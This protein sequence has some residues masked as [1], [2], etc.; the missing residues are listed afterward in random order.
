MGKIELVFKFSGFLIQFVS[1]DTWLRNP[2]EV[3]RKFPKN[4]LFSD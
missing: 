1:D 2:I 4:I 3:N